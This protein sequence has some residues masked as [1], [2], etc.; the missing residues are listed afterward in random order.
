MTFYSEEF[1]RECGYDSVDEFVEEFISKHNACVVSYRPG[2]VMVAYDA[3]SE[4]GLE[5]FGYLC[6]EA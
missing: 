4:P 1:L 6:E 2:G 3:D 5:N